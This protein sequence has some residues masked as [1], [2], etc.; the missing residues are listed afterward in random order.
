MEAPLNP[1]MQ[2]PTYTGATRQPLMMTS[3]DITLAVAIVCF[4]ILVVSCICIM[5]KLD[6]GKI[7]GRRKR[8][9]SILI[10]KA[11]KKLEAEGRLKNADQAVSKVIKKP[12]E[13]VK[14]EVKLPNGVDPPK[15]VVKT[16][17]GKP[18]VW[19]SRFEDD[20]YTE[21]EKPLP[22]VKETKPPKPGGAQPVKPAG[23]QPAKPGAPGG[24]QQAAQPK[25][26]V[27]QPVKPGSAQ[28]VKPGSAQP[29]ATAQPKKVIKDETGREVPWKVKLQEN[30][31]LLIFELSE[32]PN[33]PPLEKFPWDTTPAVANTN[34]RTRIINNPMANR[35]ISQNQT[36]DSPRF[37][38]VPKK[39]IRSDSV[40]SVDEFFEVRRPSDV[41]IDM[42]LVM[43]EETKQ[44]IF[45]FESIPNTL[46]RANG[47]N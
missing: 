19:A 3:D 25:P 45:V 30:K 21:K 17:D 35:K 22:V 9:K 41:S 5:A 37:P 11:A 39:S 2:G 10:K 44:P 27:A 42:S 8:K 43:D 18:V 14:K 36:S 47:R 13:V 24:A 12:K 16:E 7:S 20:G 40:D 31:P 28:P 26:G 4:G 38:K 33:A 15:K 1:D 34:Q 23:A 29:A 6:W 46:S 32:N